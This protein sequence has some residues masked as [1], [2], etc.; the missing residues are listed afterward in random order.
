MIEPK[1]D[2]KEAVLKVSSESQTCGLQFNTKTSP[3]PPS[4]TPAS[5]AFVNTRSPLLTLIHE[6]KSEQ[7]L[8]KSENGHEDEDDP[9]SAAIQRVIAQSSLDDDSDEMDLFTVSSS[10]AEEPLKT[11]LAT[12]ESN[13]EQPTKK[14]N[15]KKKCLGKKIMLSKE[16]VMDDSSSDSDSDSA[17]ERLIIVNEDDSTCD[18]NRSPKITIPSNEEEK[19]VVPFPAEAKSKK[20]DE[21]KNQ[22]LAPDA[23]SSKVMMFSTFL[24]NLKIHNKTIQLI[25]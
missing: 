17:E 11:N 3:E 7:E 10:V 9:I 8:K 6:D 12:N 5:N 22:T 16:F 13:S 1:S 14:L 25:C 15:S 18:S 23:S 4:L 20:G 21:L 24:H 19:K 2:D